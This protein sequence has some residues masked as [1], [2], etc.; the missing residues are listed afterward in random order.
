M[1]TT[2]PTIDA[3]L[4]PV[5]RRSARDGIVVRR[6]T[7]DPSH[8]RAP[9]AMIRAEL[10]ARFPARPRLVR[11]VGDRPATPTRC[12]AATSWSP[13]PPPS[14]AAAAGISAT[15]RRVRCVTARPAVADDTA[16]SSPWRWLEGRRARVAAKREGGRCWDTGRPLPP[17]SRHR[18][19]G[20]CPP[21]CAA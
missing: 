9:V 15:R 18:E 17:R 4:A 8:G 16:D 13:T 3:R 12:T 2:Q 14:P 6:R 11:A 5:T 20:P 7:L 19:P 10:A 21:G 1:T